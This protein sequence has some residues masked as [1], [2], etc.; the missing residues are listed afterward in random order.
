MLVS[1]PAFALGVEAATAWPRLAGEHSPWSASSPKASAARK[2]LFF[3]AAEP[4]SGRRRRQNLFRSWLSVPV[5]TSPRRYCLLMF[6]NSMAVD[7]SL[8]VI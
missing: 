1:R 7:I 8:R 3:L 2:N 4:R 5:L 6:S